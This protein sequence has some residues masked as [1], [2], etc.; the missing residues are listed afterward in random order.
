M[1]FCDENIKCIHTSPFDLVFWHCVAFLYEEGGRRVGQNWARAKTAKI[2][3]G[4]AAMAAII[5][6]EVNFRAKTENNI[7][8]HHF[9]VSLVRCDTLNWLQG[10]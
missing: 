9:F 4:Q 1:H 3:V 10:G 7:S 8:S 6:V 5:S 2:N